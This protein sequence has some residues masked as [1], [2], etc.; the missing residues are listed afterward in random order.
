MIRTRG[1]T[2]I[3]LLVVIAIIGVLAAI[4]LPALA[5]AREAARRASCQ[6]NLKQI[7]LIFKMYSGEEKSGRYPPKSIRPGNF[8]FSLPAV[9]PEYLSDLRVI[10]CPSAVETPDTYL[11]SNG[12][13]R[14][15]DGNISIARAD[16]NPL[17]PGYA[18]APTSDRCYFYFGWAIRDTAWIVPPA[19]ILDVYATNVRDVFQSS[20]PRRW[21]QTQ[22]AVDQDYSFIHSG[23]NVIVAGT[24]YSLRRLR[25]GIERFFITDINNPSA[26]SVSQSSTVSM[27]E[28]FSL[29]AESMA[30]LPGG[31]NVLFM[32]GHVSFEKYLQ[33]P[34]VTV[35]TGA[36][37]IESDPFPVNAANA[38]FTEGL[39]ERGL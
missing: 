16:G 8:L 21:E 38:L 28:N 34:E 12:R 9:Y 15:S 23:N 24:E 25:E 32:D 18:F 6:N 26:N 5:R 10:F 39:R 17:L 7:G 3:E 19:P 14:D 31:A 22:V 4:L 27:W 1:F 20:L 13:W 35:A 29:V 30:H 11:G 37:G 2:L 33:R 36:F